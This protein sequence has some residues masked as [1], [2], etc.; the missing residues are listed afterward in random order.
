MR[1]TKAVIMPG[2][3][4]R[5]VSFLVKAKKIGEI[6]VKIEAVNSLKQDSVEHILRV[7]PESHLSR[8]NEQRYIEHQGYKSTQENI[9]I[10]IPRYTLPGS[11]EI[12]FDLDRK[13]LKKH[14]S[15]GL[16]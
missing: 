14:V 6:A 8:E 11:I 7:E 16:F 12:A 5:Q 4:G 9:T 10:D 15:L 1:R 3:S 13:R 2:N